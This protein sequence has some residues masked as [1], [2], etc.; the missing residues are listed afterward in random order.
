MVGR[1]TRIFRFESWWVLEDSCEEVIRK[2]WED[3]SGSFLIP[4]DY[5]VDGLKG[6]A[7]K[8]KCKRGYDVKLLNRRLEELNCGE[9]SEENLG[10]SVGIKIQLNLEMDKEERYW[11]QRARANW[12]KIGDENTSFFHKYASQRSCVNR[13]RGLQRPHTFRGI[14]LIFLRREKLGL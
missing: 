1:R 13:I 3:S 9:R 14:F 8:I 12:L 2:I 6:W 11:E 10:E 7:K 5:L 4:M